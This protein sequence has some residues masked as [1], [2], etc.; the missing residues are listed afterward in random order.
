MA[1]AIV[2]FDDGHSGLGDDGFDEAFAAAG[3]DEIKPFVHAGHDGDAFTIGKR[4][5]L[6]GVLREACGAAAGG[7]C[8]C[9][10]AV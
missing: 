1:D 9:D 2:V 6:D 8:V 3:D 4:D 7:E 10:G 5:E